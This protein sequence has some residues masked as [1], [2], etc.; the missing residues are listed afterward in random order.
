MLLMQADDGHHGSSS[1]STEG[2]REDSLSSGRVD[3][4]AFWIRAPLAAVVRFV[5]RIS[6]I[7]VTRTNERI[8]GQT[9]RDGQA[10]GRGTRHENG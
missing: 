10:D 6:L 9:Q 2:E 7:I 1:S 4:V 8:D 3:A 5:D